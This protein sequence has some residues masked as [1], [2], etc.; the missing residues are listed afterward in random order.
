VSK[1]AIETVSGVLVDPTEP[2]ESLILLNDAAWAI[3]RINRYSGHTITKIP[4]SVAQHCIF[5][6]NM[7]WNDIHDPR[8][9]LFGLLHDTAEAYVSDIPSPIK[10]IPELKAVIEPI[11]NELL[12]ILYR[13][14]I[15][16]IPTSDDVPII[17]KYDHRALLIEAHNFMASRGRNWYGADSANIG[18]VE[19]QNFPAPMESTKAYELFMDTYEFYKSELSKV[20]Y[21]REW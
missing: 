15:G 18:F 16:F 13:K 7:I 17:K 10:R 20:K 4:Y 11:E 12:D 19:L 3:S 2:D 6:A 9:A 5:V 21:S 14:Y 1:F 8:L